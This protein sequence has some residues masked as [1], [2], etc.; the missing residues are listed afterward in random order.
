MIYGRQPSR[1][2]TLIV[3][4]NGSYNRRPSV[5]SITAWPEPGQVISDSLL[6]NFMQNCYDLTYHLAKVLPRT[7]WWL[8][9]SLGRA[10]DIVF[11]IFWIVN[12][13]NQSNKQIILRCYLLVDA[14]NVSLYLVTAMACTVLLA[15]SHQ[16][17]WLAARFHLNLVAFESSPGWSAEASNRAS[18]RTWWRHQMEIFSALLA[19]C[20]GNSPITGLF[21]HKAQ[22][23]GLLMFSLICAWIKG[24]V[25]NGDAGELTR[26]G[27]QYDVNVISFI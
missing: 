2:S 22:W 7:I 3:I 27:A 21:P 16:L 17:N 14:T 4:A 5:D 23:R 20:A 19:I 10:T 12:S 11:M 18:C 15:S 25:N 8:C 9:G 26:H 24:W 13:V 1:I 6:C